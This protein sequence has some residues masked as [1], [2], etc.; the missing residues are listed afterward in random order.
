MKGPKPHKMQPIREASINL[1]PDKNSKCWQF[2]PI[3]C[4]EEKLELIP[5]DTLYGTFIKNRI[6]ITSQFGYVGI[7]PPN[8]SVEIFNYLTNT[9]MRLLGVVLLVTNDTF[10]VEICA[11]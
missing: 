3:D 4:P 11:T 1:P 2:I 5:G 9:D 6:Q 7:V 8:E 10:L